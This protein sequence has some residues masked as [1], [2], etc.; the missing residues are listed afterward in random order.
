MGFLERKKG[1]LMRG[2]FGG[3]RD[4]YRGGRHGR[5]KHGGCGAERKTAGRLLV[6]NSVIYMS[7]CCEC[8]TR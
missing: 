6:E 5:S 8:T 2:G 4:G 1:N 3:H 7:M